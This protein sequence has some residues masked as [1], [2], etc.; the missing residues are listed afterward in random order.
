MSRHKDFDAARAEN[1]GEPL[2]FRLAGR[3]FTIERVPVGPLLD[4]AAQSDLSGAEAMAAFARFLVT[5]VVEEQRDEMR[6]ALD[7]TDLETVFGI[8]Q[9]VIEEVTARPLGQ[10]SGSPS[11]RSVD[12]PAS[13]LAAASAGWTPSG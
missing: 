4:L 1:V 13:K 9:W 8:A 7:D 3:D 2:T 12:G 6:A 10:S 11:L 5:L